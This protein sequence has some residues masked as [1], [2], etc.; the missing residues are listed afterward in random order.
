MIGQTAGGTDMVTLTAPRRGRQPQRKLTATVLVT[1]KPEHLET[2]TIIQT[3][4]KNTFNYSIT[5]YRK[6][7][8]LYGRD[9]TLINGI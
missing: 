9:S 1:T 6:G 4:I 7:K 8:F 2:N 5:N 3:C